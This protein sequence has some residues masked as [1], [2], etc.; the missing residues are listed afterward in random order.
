MKVKKEMW[1]AMIIYTQMR[2]DTIGGKQLKK[3]INK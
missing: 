3:K 1:K 2:H